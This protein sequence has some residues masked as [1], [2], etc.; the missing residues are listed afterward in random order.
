MAGENWGIWVNTRNIELSIVV[1]SALVLVCG[2]GWERLT[3]RVYRASAMEN[4]DA[5]L[6]EMLRQESFSRFIHDLEPTMTERDESGGA[7]G[8]GYRKRDS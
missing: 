4:V 3:Q 6:R 8:K 5:E 2:A 7:S 1:L